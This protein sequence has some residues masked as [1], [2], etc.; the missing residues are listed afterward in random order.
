MRHFITSVV[1]VGAVVLS[2]Q[3]QAFVDAQALIGQ[4]SATI[5]GNNV[6]DK[7]TATEVNLSVHIDPI[8]LVPV[9]FGGY[10]STLDY[11]TDAD[12]DLRAAT[13]KGTEAGLE[14]MA[15]LPMVPVITP[16]AKLGLPVYSV[17]K[18]DLIDTDPVTNVTRE[19][20][21]VMK[22][23]GLHLGIGAMWSP[24]PLVAILAQVDLGTQ[25]MKVEEVDGQD[26]NV[27]DFDYK[28]TGFLLG[29]RVS[30]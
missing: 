15:W 4:R 26:P 2:S 29:V 17:F 28:S 18:A 6:S 11:D 19:I 24:L 1:A 3:A 21:A 7:A 5:E 25:K 12:G 8:P 23:S 14:V 13:L 27:D 10:L 16:Y 20:P 30:I 9:S 22:S